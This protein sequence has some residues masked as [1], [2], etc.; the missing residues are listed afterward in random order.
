MPTDTEKAAFAIYW[1][2]EFDGDLKVSPPGLEEQYLFAQTQAGEQ[3]DS[4]P[5]TE[6]A[7]AFSSA[8]ETARKSA[9]PLGGDFFILLNQIDNYAM[10]GDITDKTR[11]MNNWA[12]VKQACDWWA[13]KMSTELQK[14]RAE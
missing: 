1:K 12:D 7:S 14:R 11:W 9:N 3:S 4:T 13:Q 5:V 6:E 2:S 8:D 10:E